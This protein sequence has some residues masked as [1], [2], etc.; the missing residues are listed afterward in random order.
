MLEGT[1]SIGFPVG[2]ESFKENSGLFFS[3]E[4]SIFVFFSPSFL[5]VEESSR[6]AFLIRSTN[7]STPIPARVTLTSAT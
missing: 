5:S 3:V 2:R 7:G 1:S 4:R 6:A